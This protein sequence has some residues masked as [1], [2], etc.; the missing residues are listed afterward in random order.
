MSL[1]KTSVLRR[2]RFANMLSP[3]AGFDLVR[4]SVMG[5]RDYAGLSD[6]SL[7]IVAQDLLEDLLGKKSFKDAWGQKKFIEDLKPAATGI[8]KQI[9][10]KRVELLT[11]DEVKTKLERLVKVAAKREQIYGQGL[12]TVQLDYDMQ[13]QRYY[14][15]VVKVTADKAQGG[16]MGASKGAL[17]WAG[18]KAVGYGTGKAIDGLSNSKELGSDRWF[19]SERT[20]LE[21]FEKI[22]RQAGSEY[23]GAGW[24]GGQSSFL[25]LRL[26]T[27]NWLQRNVDAILDHEF[28]YITGMERLIVK[29]LKESGESLHDAYNKKT[30]LCYRFWKNLKKTCELILQRGNFKA[31][32]ESAAAELKQLEERLMQ[33]SQHGIKNARPV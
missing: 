31:R 28:E 19:D 23:G 16:A 6:E 13:E 18:E 29:L 1:S 20:L 2:P 9:M 32:M 3:L 27:N 4:S 11:L 17:S 25:S 5:D 33:L 21:P 10:I 7:K 15:A 14:A 8:Y 12:E 24:L 30:E 26:D 22:W